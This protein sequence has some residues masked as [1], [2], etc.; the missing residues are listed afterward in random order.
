MMKRFILFFL[1][2]ASV[3]AGV[4]E[5]ARADHWNRIEGRVSFERRQ[6]VIPMSICQF[7]ESC[8]HSQTYWS[9]VVEA[10]T[11]KFEL[12]EPFAVGNEQA[13]AKVE[14][15]GLIVSEGARVVLEGKVESVC[16]DFGIISEIKSLA[17]ISDTSLAL[18]SELP[19]QL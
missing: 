15:S 14:L 18:P 16:D 2:T 9:L 19:G 13:P 7:P 8:P 10:D 11:G 12:D 3:M 5:K 1:F 17:V 6:T 4:G